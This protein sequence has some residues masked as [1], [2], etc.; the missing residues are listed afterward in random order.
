VIRRACGKTRKLVCGKTRM[1]QDAHVARRA[2][3]QDVQACLWFDA[4]LD[5]LALMLALMLSL[6]L[7]LMLALMLLPF[8]GRI[9]TNLL[10]R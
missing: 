8:M 7:A 5:M 1:W 2:G 6:T 4:C 10:F 9:R 3:G